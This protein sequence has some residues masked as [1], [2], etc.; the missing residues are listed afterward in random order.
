MQ[1]FTE[2]DENLLYVI[3]TT[4]DE[5]GTGSLADCQTVYNHLATFPRTQRSLRD[6]YK[7]IDQADRKMRTANDA[8]SITRI[9]VKNMLLE[10]NNVRH[11]PTRSH[12]TKSPRGEKVLLLSLTYPVSLKRAIIPPQVI[13]QCGELLSRGTQVLAQEGTIRDKGALHW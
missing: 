10:M 2:Q 5:L 6:K 13:L 9:V 3:R 8:E 1:R 11:N 12:P 7:L 4:I